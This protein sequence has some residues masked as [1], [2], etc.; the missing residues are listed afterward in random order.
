M[1]Q[2]CKVPNKVE[3]CQLWVS[4]YL[5]DTSN[6]FQNAVSTHPTCP[7]IHAQ[8]EKASIIAFPD[9]PTDNS[10]HTKFEADVGKS[11]VCGSWPGQFWIAQQ[12]ML[13][14]RPKVTWWG[15]KSFSM[16]M[17]SAQYRKTQ[18]HVPRRQG[19]PPL[20]IRN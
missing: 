5:K 11:F 3:P 17:G 8:E 12:E 19:V 14:L 4:S 16:D 20:L 18:S 6:L 13:F 15:R 9:I 7:L 2:Q 10:P 1:K